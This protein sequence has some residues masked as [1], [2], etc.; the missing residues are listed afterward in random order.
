MPP[1]EIPKQAPRTDPQ[2]LP[3]P[4]SAASPNRRKRDEM[5]RQYWI[6]CVALGGEDEKRGQYGRSICQSCYDTCKVNGSWPEQ[7]NGI[8]CPGGS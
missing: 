6:E 4:T 5:C 1:T 2:T 8:P 7:V 3:P